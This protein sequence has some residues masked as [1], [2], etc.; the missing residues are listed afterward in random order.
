MVIVKKQK[1]VKRAK[2]RETKKGKEGRS[3]GAKTTSSASIKI[4]VSHEWLAIH[5]MGIEV[6]CGTTNPQVRQND[7]DDYDGE[8]CDCNCFHCDCC[9]GECSHAEEWRTQNAKSGG[10]TNAH[11]NGQDCECMC[12][13]CA[14]CDGECDHAEEWRDEN[15]G[16]AE[17][18]VIKNWDVGS[19]GSIISD[20]MRNDPR[21]NSEDRVMMVEFRN[22]TPRSSLA[23]MKK[24][25][26]ALYDD[27]A[28]PVLSNKSCGLHVHV[29]L[30]EHM[31]ACVMN[32][33]FVLAYQ[34]ALVLDKGAAGRLAR[35][36]NS[37][38]EAQGVTAAVGSCDEVASYDSTGRRSTAFVT[39]YRAVNLGGLLYQKS[40]TK[41]WEGSTV[42]FRSFATPTTASDACEVVQFISDFLEHWCVMHVV[43]EA[44]VRNERAQQ[45]NNAVT[46]RLENFIPNNVLVNAYAIGERII[47]NNNAKE[48][49]KFVAYAYAPRKKKAVKKVASK[50][51]NKI[52]VSTTTRP[53]ARLL[54]VE[55]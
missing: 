3:Y 11:Y 47:K 15:G 27:V 18:G 30:K 49:G 36:N 51:K 22:Q 52:A 42:E 20:G 14:C 17:G 33:A 9:E 29:S 45:S 38:C 39:K 7:N 43:D 50:T 13:T 26:I 4:D 16:G 5:K 48:F 23:D 12:E 24:D 19:D 21:V 41:A 8:N 34:E 32:P 10:R 1:R 2:A 46:L 55:A 54:S 35:W 6:E 28:V 40:G 31:K 37:F 44:L 25:I 53:N